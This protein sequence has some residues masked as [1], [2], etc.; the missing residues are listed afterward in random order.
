MGPL[1][2]HL[3]AERA[4]TYSLVLA[5]AGI[6]HTVRRRDRLWTITV[7]QHDR[8]A[9]QRAVSLYLAENPTHPDHPGPPATPYPPSWS[10]L[11]AALLL[12]TVHFA[13]TGTGQQPLFFTTYGADARLILEGQLYRCITALLLHSDWAHLL[14]NIAGAALFGT[15]AA[16]L[17]GWGFSWLLI[18]LAGA[19]GNAGTAW[20]YGAHHLSVGAST[21]VFAALGLCATAAFRY[22][23]QYRSRRL[24][25]WLSLA[26][27]LAL[28]GWLGTSPRSDLL[29]HL[30]GLLCGCGLGLLSVKPLRRWIGRPLQPVAFTLVCTLILG[31]CLWGAL[32]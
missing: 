26:G 30:F 13:V 15:V 32:Y 14:G 20:W 17:Y 27:A 25:P 28:L 1:F 5:S 4:H 2:A 23:R 3:N 9:A 22:H 31:S 29:A 12:G 11:Y 16:R 10:A 7:A 24:R 21:G 8:S 19:F 6:A 18:V